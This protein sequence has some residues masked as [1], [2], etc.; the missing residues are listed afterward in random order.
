MGVGE[1]VVVTSAVCTGPT[2]M[3]HRSR[4]GKVMGW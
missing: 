4:D 2:K 3:V 1:T